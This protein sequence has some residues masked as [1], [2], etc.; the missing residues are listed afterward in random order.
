MVKSS[1]T[2]QLCGLAQAL[3]RKHSTTLTFILKPGLRRVAVDNYGYN[4]F[5]EVSSYGTEVNSASIFNT[6]FTRDKLG[7]STKKVETVQ[8][9]THTFDYFYD[10]SGRLIAVN[11]V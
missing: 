11:R 10:F 1:H 7:R 2:F 5:A 8:G 4:S 3:T 6:T 9:V